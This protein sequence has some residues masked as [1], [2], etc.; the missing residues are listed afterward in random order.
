[1][2]NLPFELGLNGTVILPLRITTILSLL[3][4][5][6]PS[7]KVVLSFKKSGLNGQLSFRPKKIGLIL[8]I[9]DKI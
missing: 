2:N 5:L 1:M 3:F 8:T 9:L 4:G 7:T 6:G